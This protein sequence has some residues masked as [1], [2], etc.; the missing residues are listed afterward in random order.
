MN[1][2]FPGIFTRESPPKRL[3]IV[4]LSAH[5]DVIHTLPLLSALKQTWPQLEIGWLTE[6]SA[7]PF[8]QNHPLIDRLHVAQRPQW[9]KA[10]R[11]PKQ[12]RT[13][14]Q[15][16]DAFIDELR[17]C[18]YEASLDVQGLLKSAVWPWL[19][20]IPVRAGYQATREWADHFY[21]HTLPPMNLL[22]PNTLAVQ[23]YLDFARAMGANVERPQFV[24]PSPSDSDQTNAIAL[25]ALVPQPSRPLVILAP[26]T[27]WPS[28]HWESDYWPPLLTK[29]LTL[30]A[31][32]VIIGGPDDIAA[33]EQILA[34]LSPKEQNQIGNLVGKTD[35]GS[36]RVLL[37]KASLLIGSD[38]APL[39][40]S[41]ALGKP[42]I[43]LY[44]PTAPGRTGPAGSGHTILSTNLPCQPCFSRQCRIQTHDCMKQLTPDIVA[45]MTER[46]LTNS[47][48]SPVQDVL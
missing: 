13:V 28:K 31:Q 39:H 15:E 32:P 25:L 43:G 38:S 41:D 11:H 46:H 20:G 35:W 2:P 1:H 4:R 26:F 37:A 14:K 44:G 23:R 9:L 17:S 5:G 10:L 27:R 45:A 8:L 29:L 42:V 6:P 36:L 48:T 12:W 33:T 34:S 22:D 18:H 3:L 24:L 21:T 30:S 47:L 19:A 40:L 16:V 7:L